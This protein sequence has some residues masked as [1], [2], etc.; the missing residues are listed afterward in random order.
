MKKNITAFLVFSL[1]VTA[2]FPK[3]FAELKGEIV[4]V[5][6]PERVDVRENFAIR[7]TAKNTGT[8]DWNN[9]YMVV[10]FDCD[11]GMYSTFYTKKCYYLGSLSVG[12][13]G[14]FCCGDDCMHY[15]GD[16]EGILDVRVSIGN[17][18]YYGAK[19]YI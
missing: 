14:T 7:L 9:V 18:T 8:E 3:A 12:D 11:Y 5:E 2:T 10:H 16:S 17:Q 1:V 15:S 19:K 6:H 4:K 13:T